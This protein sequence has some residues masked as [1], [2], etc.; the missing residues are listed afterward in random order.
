MVEFFLLICSWSSLH[1]ADCGCD[2]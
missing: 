1:C 2:N